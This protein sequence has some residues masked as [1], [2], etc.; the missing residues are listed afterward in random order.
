MTDLYIMERSDAPGIVKIGSSQ[1]PERRRQQLESGHTF[2]MVL[3]AVFHT[4]VGLNIKCIGSLTML[5][6]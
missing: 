3:L 1:N 4:R 2:R 6:S 5:E